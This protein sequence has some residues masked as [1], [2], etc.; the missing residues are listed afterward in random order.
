MS[1]REAAIGVRSRCIQEAAVSYRKIYKTIFVL[2]LSLSPL[3]P[4]GIALAQDQTTSSAL[5]GTVTDPTGAVIPEATVTLRGA[6][7]GVVRT[8]KTTEAGKYS[9]QLLPPSTYELRVSASGFKSYRQEGLALAAGQTATQAVDLEIG[10]SAEEVT[11][12]S[13]APLL[14]ADNANLSADIS[15]KQAVELPLNLRNVYGL[16]TLNSSVQNGTEGQKV[17]GGGTQD[18]ADQDIS[19]LNFGGG[20]FGTTAYMLDGIWDTASDWGAVVYVP[21]VDSVDQFKIQTNSFT[22]QYGF[23]TGNVINVT[24]K[25]GTSAF[26][27]SVYE[28]LRND[29]LDANA[30]FNNFY[31]NP[32]PSFRRNQ[33]GISAGGPLYI[34]KLYRQTQ[35]TFIF[36]LYEGLR[37]STPATFTGTVPTA[38]FLTGNFSALLGSQLTN[39]SGAPVFDDLGRP[40][41]T[42][43][44]YNPFS[45][46]AVT[47]GIVDPTTGLKATTTGFVRDPFPGNTISPTQF[48]AVGAAIAKFYP[49]ATTSGISNNFSATASAPATANEYL[50]RVD[51]NI[52]DATRIFGRWAQKYEFKTNSPAFFGASNPGGPGNIRPNNR[53]S[54]VVGGSHVF[55]PTFAMSATAGLSRWAEGGVTQSYPFSQATLGLPAYL[56]IASPIFPLVSVTNQVTL[57]PSQGTQGTAFRNVGSVSVDFTKTKG[58][59]DLSFGFMGAILQNNG[60]SL[61][62]TSFNIDQGFTGGP[63]PTATTSQTGY[64]F[65]SL[66]LGTA[67]SGT[68]ANNFNAAIT[69]YYYGFYT[70]DDW[71][72]TQHLTLNL[73]LRY[74]WQGAPT[75]RFNRQAYFDFNAINPISSQLGTQL[76]GEIVFNGNGN[77]RGLYST[78]YSNV[79]PRI[80]FADQV[81]P[82]L[83]L[84]G[85]YGIFFSPQ[86]FGG[87]YNPGYSQSTPYTGSVNSGLTPFTTLSNPF[88]GGLITPEGDAL[89]PLQDVGQQTTAVPSS[90]RSPYV[91][92]FSFGVQT[93]FTPND[94]LSVTYVG[95]HGTKLLLSSFNHSQLNPSYYSLGAT[96]ND[97]VPNPFYGVITTSGCGLN[98]PTIA[99]GHLLSPYPQYCGVSEPQA[100]VGFSL[101][102]ALQADYNHRFHA[103]LN[104][105]VSY[106]Y[107]KFLDNVSGTNN[108]S[109][110]G[111]QGPQ[112]YY[113]LAAEKSVDGGDTP[114]SLVVN[115]IYEL[116][117]G[118]GRHFAGHINKAT[119]AVI[120]GWQISGITSAKSGFP[121]SVS[122]GG[123]SNLYGANLRPNVVSNPKLSHRTINRWFD[124]LAFQPLDP[125]FYGFGNEPRYLSR[126]RSPGYQ[127]W[128][129]AL[130]KY[131]NF[132]EGI[133]LQGRAEFFNT[134]NH[135]NFYAPDTALG[136]RTL[137][138]D[139]STTDVT[140]GSF[141]TIRSAFGARDI[142][143]ALKLYW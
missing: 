74:E 77:R 104:I 2:L 8:F 29:K 65:A 134:F 140:A 40:V 12:T 43:A 13:Q 88:P 61:P 128:D 20:F 58:A 115:Y 24:T 30:Y 120:G 126:L 113:D 9:F 18:T 102:D 49:A 84:R 62:T 25:S 41:I 86:W 48:N 35:K 139:S 96:L 129:M 101:Y 114:H 80:G 89:G 105:L 92:N 118:R 103:G 66:L 76:P 15:S 137:L 11:V 117:V 16:A 127:D 110:T 136:D 116:P 4:R 54:F 83:V 142:Q 34:P 45:G 22:A 50:I 32:K 132:G 135:P 37:Q 68:T 133:K 52:S 124:P 81:T 60:N 82:K 93:A 64:G 10:G 130:Q 70:E 17:N 14:N 106:T 21:S 47:A 67:A 79:A 125:G 23:S 1:R 98:E 72:A 5:N 122:G 97:Q 69:K 94:V 46:R 3:F 36:G 123:G 85:G 27:G 121:L 57:G 56:D 73:G 112:N 107:S 71:K 7:N 63:D 33:F 95:N 55:A 51:H 141:G 78:S 39:S 53:F 26:H 19:F 42:G 109:Y 6:E 108:W 75:E 143:F 44:I 28:F 91:Q 100:P 90:R 131:W 38:D 111:D 59:H 31:G 119:D 99:R 87:G 138:P